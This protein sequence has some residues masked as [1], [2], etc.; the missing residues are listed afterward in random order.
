[1]DQFPPN[2]ICILLGACSGNLPD[3]L[4]AGCEFCTVFWNL[5]LSLVSYQPTEKEVEDL[6][7]NICTVFPNQLEISICDK[8][9]SANYPKLVQDLIQKYPASVTCVDVNACPK[10]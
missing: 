2:T 6:L 8:F 5:C 4:T 7:E 10:Q 9:I 3:N 1:V